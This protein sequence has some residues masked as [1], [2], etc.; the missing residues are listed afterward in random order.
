VAAGIACAIG[1]SAR[2][3]VTHSLFSSRNASNVRSAPLQ[4]SVRRYEGP[5]SILGETI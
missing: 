5:W 3:S 1:A 4:R 2:F